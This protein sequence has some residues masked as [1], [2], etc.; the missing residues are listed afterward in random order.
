MAVKDSEIIRLMKVLEDT[1]KVAQTA[2]GAFAEI[3]I[4]GKKMEAKE[5]EI[6]KLK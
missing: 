5:K 3:E 6:A 2:F 1:K 4:N